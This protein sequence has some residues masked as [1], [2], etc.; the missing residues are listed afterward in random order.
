M[1]IWDFRQWIEKKTPVW[2][3][4]IGYLIVLFIYALILFWSRRRT[5]KKGFGGRYEERV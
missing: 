3:I 2:I 1:T 4:P 5:V